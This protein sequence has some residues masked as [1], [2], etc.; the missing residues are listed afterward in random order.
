MCGNS[1]FD[2]KRKIVLKVP[3]HSASSLKFEIFANR[4]KFGINL[5]LLFL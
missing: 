4:V 2:V 1:T 3:N 5:F